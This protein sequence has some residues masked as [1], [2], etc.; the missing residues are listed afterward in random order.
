MVLLN[1]IYTT[2]IYNHVFISSKKHN[3]AEVVGQ[4]YK[5]S[6]KDENNNKTT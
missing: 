4:R 1:V 3:D 6:I 2:L 5:G